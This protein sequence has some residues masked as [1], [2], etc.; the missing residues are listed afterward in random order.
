MIKREQILDEISA[1][2]KD[3]ITIGVLGS[4]SALDICD[5]ARDEGIPNL[6]ICQ[7][8]RDALYTKY[9]K[10]REVNRFTKGFV[11]ATIVL[12]KF[13]LMLNDDI[14]ST[15]IKKNTLFIPNRSFV[16]YNGIRQV[17]ND[18]MVPLIGT[19]DMLKIENRET[20]KENY[21]WVSQQA[22]IAIPKQY[23]NKNDID[24]LVMVKLHHKH[25]TLERGFFTAASPEEF[26]EKAQR[27]LD[28]DI[29]TKEALSQARIEQ[30][31]IG[32]V[33]NFNFFYSPIDDEIE[34][35][36]VDFRF[37][38]NLD[39]LVRIPAAQQ[40][41]IAAQHRDPLM[42]IVGHANASLRESLLEQ[43]YLMA[44]KFVAFSK[45]H[46]NTSIIGPFCLQT[47]VDQNM[48][49]YVYDI[50][51]RIGGGTNIHTYSG[52]PYGNS[53]FRT[54]MSSGRRL[55][56]EIKRALELDQLEKIV[57]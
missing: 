34:L 18:F 36:G 44:E 55:A 53:L 20:E 37:E 8:G 57:T 5:G 1:Y 2:D 7:K 24:S 46:Y 54:R 42:V 12:D 13:N 23:N 56:L 41:E 30:Y 38:S 48:D 52:A 6:V 45:R 16:V 27:L 51:T 9:F 15:L 33:F 22:G 3:N 39:G 29:I 10:R 14:Q 26:D 28:R 47:I 4:H 17:E 19:R 25:M 49:F 50:A 11:D 32:P 21:Y 40:L 43:V 31:I 35:L